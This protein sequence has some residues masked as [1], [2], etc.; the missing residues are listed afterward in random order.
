MG[1]ERSTFIIDEDG[2]VLEILRKVKVD[3]HVQSVLASL[4]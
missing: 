4:S 2:I 3:G 1:V